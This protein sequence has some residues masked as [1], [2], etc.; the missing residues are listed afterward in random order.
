[1]DKKNVAALL[2]GN[3]SHHLDHLAPLCSLMQMPLIFTDEEVAASYKKYYPNPESILLDPLSGPD[4]IV[5]NYDLLFYSMPRPLFEEIF[6]FAERLFRKK[7]PTIWIPHGN[8]DKGSDSVFMEALAEEEVALLYGKRIIDFL[9]KKHVLE[10]FKGYVITGNLR[11]TYYQ[12]EKPFFQNLIKQHIHRKLKKAVRT[13]LYAPT[14]QDYEKSSSFFDAAPLL[15]ET[16]PK[17]FNL[18]IKLHPN[19]LLQQEFNVEALIEKYEG[20]E[21]ILFLKEFPPIYPLLDDVDIYLGDASSIG[22]DF[23]SFNKPLFFLKQTS[24]PL[25]LHQAGVVIEKEDYPRIYQIIDQNLA[26]DTM[27]FAPIRKEL[28]EETFGKEKPWDLLKE[29]IIKTYELFEDD[30]NFL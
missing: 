1:M 15:L 17:E 22:Y 9:M 24:T 14:W 6:F 8:S 25:Y 3:Q 26:N 12:K 28:Y 30:L 29:E 23:L 19:L 5:K 2:Y 16:L 11:Y 7:I 4:W 27:R 20:E 21:N 18:I 10:K 13:I